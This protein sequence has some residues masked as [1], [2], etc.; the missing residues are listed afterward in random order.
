VRPRRHRRRDETYRDVIGKLVRLY[1]P[2]TYEY[3]GLT[4]G[5]GNVDLVIEDRSGSRS[6]LELE[7]TGTGA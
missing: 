5:D 2:E 7:R 1:L 6:T 4:D 3:L